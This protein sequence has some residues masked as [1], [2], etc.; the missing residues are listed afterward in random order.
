VDVANQVTRV[1]TYDENHEYT[2]LVRVMICSTGRS[3]YPS[4]TGVITLP[5][6]KAR[7]CTFPNW[8]G[9]TAMYWT[10]IDENVAFHSILYANYDPGRPNMSSFN[11]LGKRASH[12]CIRLHTMDAKWVYDNIGAGTV[13]SIVEHM[14]RD[15]ELRDALKLP[16]LNSEK[17]G[18]INTPQPTA[19]PEYSAAAKPD[20]N[21]GTLKKG[22]ESEKVYWVQIRLKE[23]GFYTTKCTG[24]MLDRTVSA[25][26]EF[27]KSRGIYPSGTVSQSL[28][29]VMAEPAEEEIPMPE[30]TPAPPEG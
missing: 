23:L 29:D 7:W 22:S 24:K 18:P 30:A 21:G 26:K 10:K 27:Q 2:K 20:L 13:V 16:P 11:N 4:P 8:G 15:P 6:R 28:I 17:T 25:V 9:G 3:K 5:G 12:G 19:E 1:Y 14:P